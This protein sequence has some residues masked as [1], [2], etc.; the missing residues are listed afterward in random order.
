MQ[1]ACE[2]FLL[3]DTDCLELI[4]EVLEMFGAGCLRTMQFQNLFLQRR[5]YFIEAV[6]Q[7]SVSS[8][9]TKVLEIFFSG[10]HDLGLSWPLSIG[11]SGCILRI[12]SS[13]THIVAEKIYAERTVTAAELRRT[14]LEKVSNH[15]NVTVNVDANGNY[16]LN[17]ADRAL[18][19]RSTKLVER[20]VYRYLAE[21]RLNTSRILNLRIAVVPLWFFASLALRN[22]I[23]REYPRGM[24]GTLWFPDLLQPDPFFIL[25]V[26]VGALGFCNFLCFS[27]YWFVIGLTALVENQA[28]R[29]SRFRKL[30][31]IHSLPSDSR[32]RYC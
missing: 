25:P 27:L 11:L 10:I 3:V 18:S 31:G 6:L 12:L 15:H 22:I 20:Y 4:A 17:T 14:L 30:L 8:Y 23:L 26:G 24:S 28:L 21:N 29:S 32:I 5:R 2:C 7:Y 19:R 13:P 16:R 9:Y 1:I